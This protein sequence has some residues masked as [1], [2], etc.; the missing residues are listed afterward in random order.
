MSGRAM[1]PATPVARADSPA[2]SVV[3]NRWLAGS[4]M[5]EMSESQGS[6]DNSVSFDR[7]S[8]PQPTGE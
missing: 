7:S 1:R 8:E 2:T 5:G 3:G 6:G 4:G